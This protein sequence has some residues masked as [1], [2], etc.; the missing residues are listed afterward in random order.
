[1]IFV[2]TLQ[3]QTIKTINAMDIVIKYISDNYPQ[4]LVY[5]FVGSIAWM[6]AKYHFSIQATRKKVDGLPCD[7]HSALLNL[8]TE[9]LDKIGNILANVCN[10]L[11]KFEAKFDAIDAKM[12]NHGSVLSSICTAL[13]N[14]KM[15]DP[16]SVFRKLSPYRLTEVGENY[17]VSSGG[18]E[19]IDSNLDFFIS[20]LEKSN[21]TTALDVETNSYKLL[22]FSS[23]KPFFKRIKDYIFLDP[24]GMPF[25][26]AAMIMS[27]Y[28]RDKYLEVHPEL[29]P[30]N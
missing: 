20:E 12:E 27:I 16:A 5:L 30:S 4:L 3:G 22:L 14:K 19:C 29:Y 11:A 28:L 2:V 7:S 8:H 1:M 10:A 21:P 13:V 23:E 25:I 17:L 15:L 18:K 6:L 26:T 9:K 24:D